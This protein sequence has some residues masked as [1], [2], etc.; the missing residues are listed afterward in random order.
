MIGREA[1][2]R[3]IP[4]QGA[5][6]MLDAVVACDAIRIT[7]HSSRHL[8]MDNPLRTR[9]RLSSIHG[10]EF[11]AQAM[12]AHQQLTTGKRAA[13]VRYGLLISVRQCTFATDRLDRCSSPLTIDAT[14]V[15]ATDEALTYHFSIGAAGMTLVSGRASVLLVLD[16]S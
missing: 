1:I 2:A 12:A 10:I 4:H 8:D 6:C 11:A 3:L 7:C 9:D 5:M 15:A 13:P 16:A 14:R